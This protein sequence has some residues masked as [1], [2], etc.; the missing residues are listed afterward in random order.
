MVYL[1]APHRVQSWPFF[2]QGCGTCQPGASNS[3]TL[4]PYIQVF[5]TDTFRV[6]C[7]IRGSPWNL[8]SALPPLRHIGSRAK[9][10]EHTGVTVQSVGAGHGRR[11]PFR[12]RF[13]DISRLQRQRCVGSR[14]RDPG[15]DIDRLILQHGGCPRWEM[16]ISQPGPNCG[17]QLDR[18]ARN[19]ACF[20]LI[21]PT[22]TAL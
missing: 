22:K 15:S 18:C 14:T 8:A 11:W 20:N 19:Q 5:S 2:C 9:S 16:G 1:C 6:H 13:Q 4:Y 21:F 7:P 10:P 12:P 17:H 3:F